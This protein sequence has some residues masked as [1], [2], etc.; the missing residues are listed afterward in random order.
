MHGVSDRLLA[1]RLSAH[2]ATALYYSDVRSEEGGG[3]DTPA[4]SRELPQIAR[5]LMDVATQLVDVA[6]GG[7]ADDAISDSSSWGR[8]FQARVVEMLA[9]IVIRADEGSSHGNNVSQDEGR[10]DV[11]L[12]TLLDNGVVDSLLQ[13]LASFKPTNAALIQSTSIVC[14][15]HVGFYGY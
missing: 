12:R 3:S 13:Y 15:S 2:L 11:L 10:N 4:N 6:N 5:E 14:D 1:L 9:D 8:G 7:S